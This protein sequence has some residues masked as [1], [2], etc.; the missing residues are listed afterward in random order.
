MPSPQSDRS[1]RD[2]R[3]ARDPGVIKEHAETVADVIVGGLT[4]HTAPA[5]IP[6]IASTERSL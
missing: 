1:H 4:G 6:S 3:T 2:E 5:Q